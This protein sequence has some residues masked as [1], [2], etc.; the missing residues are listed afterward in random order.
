MKKNQKGFT[1]VE[2]IVV[3]V[4]MGIVMAGA[5][6]IVNPISRAASKIK[7][8]ND[9][10][11]IAIYVARYMSRE[12]T[13]ATKVRIYGADAADPLPSVSNEYT[14]IYVIDNVTPRA[15]SKKGCTGVVRRG[16]WTGSSIANDFAVGQEALYAEEEFNITLSEYSDYE[17]QAYMTLDFA[18]YSMKVDGSG[19]VRDTDKTYRYKE[20]VEFI[21]VN[22]R[23]S[24]YKPDGADQ[25]E[26]YIDPS[27]NS[28]TEK[29][30]IFF[31]PALDTVF[32]SSA[33]GSSAYSSAPSSTTITP[34]SATP[35][36]VTPSS[37]TPS[38][39]PSS[40]QK[41]KVVFDSNGSQ[42]PVNDVPEGALISSYAPVET[43]HYTVTADADKYF[44][45]GWYYNASGTG[46]QAL[47]VSADKATLGII[48]VYKDWKKGVEVKFED[49]EGN[50]INELTYYVAQNSSASD[51]GEH[52]TPL[53]DDKEFATWVNKSNNE[54][55]GQPLSGTSVTYKPK[56]KDKAADSAKI[57]INYVFP[58][59]GTIT[60][61][62]QAAFKWNS[63]EQGAT[64]YD[65]PWTVVRG[66]N[67]VDKFTDVKSPTTIKIGSNSATVSDSD[68]GS[69]LE[70]YYYLDSTGKPVFSKTPYTETKL[71]VTLHFVDSPS[72]MLLKPSTTGNHTYFTDENGT[73]FDITGETTMWNGSCTGTKT[74]E[75]YCGTTF[76]VSSKTASYSINVNG[77]TTDL[78]IYKDMWGDWNI[79]NTEPPT[80]TAFTVQF[81]EAPADN[82]ILASTS[83]DIMYDNNLSNGSGN[84]PFAAGTCTAGSTHVFK[85][86]A[87]TT[88]FVDGNSY[89]PV[90][91]DGGDYKAYYY[92]GFYNSRDDAEAAYAADHNGA[93]S[94]TGVIQV[95]WSSQTYKPNDWGEVTTGWVCN[96]V[97]NTRAN[98]GDE[99]K[100]N[101]MSKTI[102]MSA[103][104]NLNIYIN[105]NWNNRYGEVNYSYDQL[106]A[107]AVTDIWIM[108]DQISTVKPT[109]WV[110]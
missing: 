75:L 83:G 41:F 38:P 65:K 44:S 109:D 89:G 9:E 1:L 90:P 91:N 82:Q 80:I 27:V 15:Y 78:Y 14:S 98:D 73:P 46:E 104:E 54:E 71:A 87:D 25:F 86:N 68:Y 2:L 28:K 63:A 8:Q 21:N 7:S 92:N 69:T 57:N 48:T 110:D 103:G 64:W 4:L 18:G 37:V 88:F 39:S 77:S 13:Y 16:Q 102:N 43:A 85:L 36:S 81:L 93:S 79:D 12:L 53:E 95:H 42:F 45:T 49:F 30:Y 105:T 84:L 76:T 66:K 55:I 40:A 26:I 62:T 3:M 5:L 99:W 22:S 17:G 33:Y 56:S 11:S 23:N 20:S 32:A 107:D 70:Y 97:G 72:A 94:F 29:L 61:N 47:T 67:S 51:P 59:D 52:P 60:V 96:L 6:A 34:S 101:D 35:S 50:V 19:Y 58:Y 10:E 100:G 106:E 74:V 108:K 31:V 24:L